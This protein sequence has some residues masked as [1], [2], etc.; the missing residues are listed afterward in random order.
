MM[1]IKAD[2]NGLELKIERRQRPCIW[3]GKT[4]SKA[5]NWLRK[6][7][8]LH[9]SL[10]VLFSVI[11]ALLAGRRRG[12]GRLRHPCNV[13]L[14]SDFLMTS[15]A[16]RLNPTK[17]VQG[18]QKSSTKTVPRRWKIAYHQIQGSSKVGKGME[19]EKARQKALR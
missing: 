11:Y 16:P 10:S 18:N 9:G 15:P 5:I 4:T 2:V 19:G 17:S 14:H 3:L 12:R 7:S 1:T 13:S 8:F 6:R